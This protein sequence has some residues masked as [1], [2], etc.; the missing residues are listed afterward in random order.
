MSILAIL[1]ILIVPVAESIRVEKDA[2]WYDS[3]STTQVVDTTARALND[4]LQRG[5]TAAWQLFVDRTLYRQA[6]VAYTPGI[7]IERTPSSIPYEGIEQFLAI[8]AY[9]IPRALWRDKPILSRGNWFAIT[10]LNQPDF[11]STSAAITVFGEGY[12]FS[13]WIGAALACLILGLLLA[14]LYQNT[15]AVGLWPIYLALVPTFVDV[16]GQFTGMIVALL[17]RIVVFTAFYWLMVRLSER[18]PR[19]LKRHAD[20]AAGQRQVRSVSGRIDA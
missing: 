13:G 1:G 5:P 8:P 20:G 6:T 17:Q 10:Y 15:A 4:T 14:F 18:Q 9:V 16:E 19:P 12:M 11:L 2:G 7:I 3:S